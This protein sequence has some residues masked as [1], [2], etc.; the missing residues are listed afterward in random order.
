MLINEFYSSRVNDSLV[1]YLGKYLQQH[2]PINKKN[3]Y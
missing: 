2:I 3:I 1:F